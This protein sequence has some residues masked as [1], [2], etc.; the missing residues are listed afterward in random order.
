MSNGKDRAN[1][2]RPR[3]L[4]PCVEGRVGSEACAATTD[5]LD[6][7][8]MRLICVYTRLVHHSGEFERAIEAETFSAYGGCGKIE[9]PSRNAQ[10]RVL[11]RRHGRRVT[12]LDYRSCRGTTRAR[13]R[14][15]SATRD[16]GVRGCRR[17]VSRCGRPR[18]FQGHY[19]FARMRWQEWLRAGPKIGRPY[20]AVDDVVAAKPSSWPT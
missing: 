8:Y 10:G 1:G 20:H 16:V 11:V 6:I 9:L 15:C 18:E 12:P 14:W 17:P 7:A 13:R 3:F 19:G 5:A 4:D 2:F